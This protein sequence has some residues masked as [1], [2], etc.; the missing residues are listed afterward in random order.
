MCNTSFPN[1]V[2]LGKEVMIDGQDNLF[3]NI[4][5]TSASSFLSITDKYKKESKGW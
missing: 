1:E 3:V 4:I 2:S 5:T